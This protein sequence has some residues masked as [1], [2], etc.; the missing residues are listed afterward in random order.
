MTNHAHNCIQVPIKELLETAGKDKDP[1][2]AEYPVKKP[3]GKEKGELKFTFKFAEKLP[4]GFPLQAPPSMLYTAA[5][6]QTPI[7]YPPVGYPQAGLGGRYG[8]LPQGGSKDM[9]PPL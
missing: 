3:S 4:G 1:K 7:G 9:A 6:N 5:T 2:K 8:L